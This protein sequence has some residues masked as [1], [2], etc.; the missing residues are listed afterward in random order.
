M[1]ISPSTLSPLKAQT[2]R[3]LLNPSEASSNNPF[4]LKCQPL[5]YQIVP[6]FVFRNI[7]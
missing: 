7:V 2:D 1:Y 4:F 3:V 6:P 5:L